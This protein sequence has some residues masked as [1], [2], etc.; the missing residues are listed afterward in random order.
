MSPLQPAKLNVT[1]DPDIQYV[2]TKNSKKTWQTTVK[3]NG[4]EYN[5]KFQTPSSIDEKGAKQ[6]LYAF[7][8]KTAS[9]THEFF[10]QNPSSYERLEVKG[11]KILGLKQGQTKLMTIGKIKFNGMDYVFTPKKK[12]EKKKKRAERINELAKSISI[13]PSN[14][15]AKKPTPSPAKKPAPNPDPFMR[16]ENES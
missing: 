7:I 2:G 4:K 13:R 3:I 12:T 10:S 8:D 16:V 11:N 15:P 6:E 9:V 5:V 14:A 1:Y